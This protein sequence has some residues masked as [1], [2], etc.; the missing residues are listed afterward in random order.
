MVPS[1]V[2]RHDDPQPHRPARAPVPREPVIQQPREQIDREEDHVAGVEV[3][4]QRWQDHRDHADGPDER[5]IAKQV[6]AEPPGP[7]VAGELVD[8]DQDL[9]PDDRPEHDDGQRVRHQ[10]VLHRVGQERLAADSPGIPPGELAVAQDGVP[11]RL[12]PRVEDDLPVLCGGLQ[13]RTR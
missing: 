12:G 10:H 13:S 7:L 4:R 9:E 3:Q 8:D 6:A 2:E 1:S 11:Q 5:P